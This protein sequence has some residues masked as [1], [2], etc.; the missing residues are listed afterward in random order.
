MAS[1]LTRLSGPALPRTTGT[2][3]TAPITTATPAGRLTKNIHRHDPSWISSEP[4]SNPK[5][6]AA[7]VTA[8]YSPVARDRAA[9]S[10]Q[11]TAISDRALADTAAAPAPC[12]ARAA[13]RYPAPGASP[14]QADA[15][16]NTA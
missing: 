14:A 4:A 9:G 2:S 7:P 6:P 10:G 5:A 1:A 12:P 16:V 15:A 3:T 13:S 8:A 11:A